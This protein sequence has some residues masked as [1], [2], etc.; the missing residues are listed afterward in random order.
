MEIRTR[1]PLVAIFVVAL[2]FGLAAQPAV[3]GPNWE[4]DSGTSRAQSREVPAPYRELGSLVS[5]LGK[6]NTNLTD[7]DND[8]LPD[9]IELVIGTDPAKPDSDFDNIN[10][11]AEISLKLDPKKPDSNDDG[12]PDYAEVTNIS[13]DLDGDG[14]AN[15]WDPD[16]DN[17]GVNDGYD[18]SPNAMTSSA[19]TKTFRLVTSGKPTYINFQLSPKDSRHLQQYSKVWNWPDDCEG[20][21]Q[22]LDKSVDDVTISPILSLEAP[23]LPNQSDMD[24]EGIVIADKLA[25]IPLIPILDL[26]NIVALEGRMFYPGGAPLNI[27]LT[28]KMSWTVSGLTDKKVSALKVSNDKYIFAGTDGKVAVNSSSILPE[29]KFEE[30]RS[31]DA[32]EWV[33]FKAANGRYLAVGK[34]NVVEATGTQINDSS[35]FAWASSSIVI[36]HLKSRLTEKFVNKRADGTLVAD[37]PMSAVSAWIYPIDAGC[38]AESTPLVVYPEEFFLAGLSI[39]ENFGDDLGLFWGGSVSTMVAANLMMAYDFLR[40]ATTKVSEIPGMLTARNIAVSHK[41]MT[42]STRDGLLMH[43]GGKPLQEIVATLPAHSSLPVISIFTDRG[44]SIDLA[45]MGGGSHVIGNNF[46]GDVSKKPLLVVKSLK[47]NWYDT[48]SD[49]QLNTTEVIWVLRQLGLAQ[50][51]FLMLSSLELAWGKGERIVVQVGPTAEDFENA[52]ASAVGNWIEGVQ[53]YGINYTMKL[54][55]AYKIGLTVYAFLNLG[56]IPELLKTSLMTSKIDEAIECWTWASKAA[57]YADAIEKISNVLIVIGC[58]ISVALAG[59]TGWLIMKAYGYSEYGIA[60]GITSF[61]LNAGYAIALALLAIYGGPVG[62][63]I[64]AVLAIINLIFMCLGKEDPISKAIGWLANQIVKHEQRTEPSLE[65]LGNAFQLQDRQHNGLDRGDRL[66][67]ILRLNGIITKTSKGKS[68]DLEDSYIVPTLYFSN[69]KGQLVNDVT[70]IEKMDATHDKKTTTYNLSA[71]TDASA[72]VNFPFTTVLAYSYQTYYQVK[73]IGLFTSHRKTDSGSKVLDPNTLYFDVMPSTF[74]GLMGWTA[75]SSRDN[76]ADGLN[77]TAETRSDPMLN[78]TDADGLNDKFE[79]D[80]GTDPRRSDTDADGLNDLVELRAGTDPFWSDTDGDGLSDAVEY[81]GW[82]TS[83]EFCGKEFSWHIRS[84]PRLNDT[85]SDGLDD[86]SER[87]RGLNPLS[88][89]TDGNGIPDR[90]EY[91]VHALAYLGTL[92]VPSGSWTEVNPLSVEYDGNSYYVLWHANE[93]GTVRHSIHRYLSTGYYAGSVVNF[94][95]GASVTDIALDAS[96]NIYACGIRIVSGNRDGLVKYRGNGTALGEIQFDYAGTHAWKSFALDSTGGF[97]YSANYFNGTVTRYNLTT[98]NLLKTWEPAPGAN[99]YQGRMSLDSNRNLYCADTETGCI[100]KFNPDMEL[101][102]TFNRTTPGNPLAGPGDVDIAPNGD[103]FVLDSNAHSVVK[104]DFAG[105]YYTAFGTNGTGRNNLCFPRAVAYGDDKVLVVDGNGSGRVQI[106][107]NSVWYMPFPS[108]TFNDT[109]GDGLTD[110]N[111]S[112]GWNVTV[113]VAK[114][115][116]TYR[117]TSEPLLPDTDHDGLPDLEE[118]ALG[119]DPRKTDTDGDG[120]SDYKEWF[121][122]GR[123]VSVTNATN[124]DTDEDGLGDGAEET[125]GSDPDAGDSDGDGLSDLSEFELGTDPNSNDTDSDGLNDSA[126]VAFGSS[127]LWAD[128]DGDLMIDSIE[129]E[130]GTNPNSNDT[131]GDGLIDGYELIYGTDAN[132]TDSD[133]DGLSDGFELE[134]GLD[135]LSSDTDH[136]GI[137]DN[138]ELLSGT[139]PASED[140]DSDGTLDAEDMYSNAPVEG[141]AWLVADNGTDTAAFEQELSKSIGVVRI[142]LQEFNDHYKTEKYIIVAGDP[143]AANGT[144][145]ELMRDVLSGA[146]DVLESVVTGAD[147]VSVRYGV[148][149]PEQTVILLTNPR[150]KVSATVLEIFK[151][152]SMTV[153]DRSVSVHYL[154]PEKSE[155]LDDLTTIHTTDAAVWTRLNQ[156]SR[157]NITLTDY[158]KAGTPAALTHSSGMATGECPTGNYLGV[159]YA[160]GKIAQTRVLMFFTAADL[161]RNGDGDANDTGDINAT[162]LVLYQYNTTTG[163]WTKLAPTLDW[164]NEVGLNTTGVSLYGKDYAGYIYANVTYTTLFAIAGKPSTML[165]AVSSAGSDITLFVED[166]FVLN[167]SLSSGDGPILNYTWTM[168]YGGA[169]ITRYGPLFTYQP[170]LPGNYSATLTITDSLGQKASDTVLVTVKDRPDGSWNLTVGPVKDSSGTAVTA[171]TVKIRIGTESLSALTDGQGNARIVAKLAHIGQT[172]TVTVYKAGYVPVEYQT[173]ITSDRKLETSPAALVRI[174]PGQTG[175]FVVGPV[176]NTGGKLLA[177]ATVIVKLDRTFYY[178]VTDAQGMARLAI[179]LT[180]DDAQANVTIHKTGYKDA[181]YNTRLSA[182]MVPDTAPPALKS[183]QT[184]T[185]TPTGSPQGQMVMSLLLL[186]LLIAAIALM[187][188]KPSSRIRKDEP[189]EE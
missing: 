82:I 112:A 6:V 136:D 151:K 162:T 113:M 73:Y 1:Y 129:M 4:N 174:T 11:S 175:D 10:D 14:A 111:E 154:N 95:A 127:P 119:T 89:D 88:G 37:S 139:D 153:S 63:A 189:S 131:D 158:P 97:L 117:V 142:A 80:S 5:E 72:A 149:A 156:Q 184:A 172:V 161:D 76:D 187:V 40:N 87:R 16:N 21:M 93:S 38:R 36:L 48:D 157:F 128:T 91:S 181:S 74:D 68:G 81:A 98:G 29:T 177:G 9:N 92:Q 110:V 55:L 132:A 19:L 146:P 56:K 168:Q 115:A 18:L 75:L 13:L 86:P 101:A 171:A 103:L 107:S 23:Y 64:V 130:D 69:E 35:Q 43:L 155:A 109:D 143:E 102:A 104:L 183:I 188:V 42:V 46:T 118:R 53:K 58:V 2:F 57:K 90:N 15:A 51:E 167:G 34:N 79:L 50:D 144:C 120:L 106:L 124:D 31:G 133:H 25:N 52:E 152:L 178:A 164:V 84:D 116:K 134:S 173:R 65:S 85:D 39:E 41:V 67:S 62:M 20:S 159:D 17:D 140:T 170:A 105:F 59:V 137:S 26:G 47:T 160:T 45:E 61:V 27:S 179:P 121:A 182:G 176:K 30:I 169:T 99:R 94:S 77:N 60:L 83:F 165:P 145:G 71:W 150:P 148:W 108:V 166:N 32:N 114:K 78:D 28:L 123:A 8:G 54:I 180:G 122:G 138:N 7:S 44:T 22:D 125:F 3:A 49:T 163:N 126:E 147:E 100:Y 185:T 12:Y 96:G 24:A 70:Y 66:T 33:S 186:V 135:P 141:V